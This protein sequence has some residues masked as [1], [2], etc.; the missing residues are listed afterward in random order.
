MGGELLGPPRVRPITPPAPQASQNFHISVM[1]LDLR[2]HLT[3]I[4]VATSLTYSGFGCQSPG[5]YACD[6]W[7]A[8][9]SADTHHNRLFEVA[10]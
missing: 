4:Y 1:N 10:G 2:W 9:R 3:R 6:L 5:G 7:F 8:Q